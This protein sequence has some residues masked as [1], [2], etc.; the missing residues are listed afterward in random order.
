M[1]KL[2]KKVASYYELIKQ[3]RGEPM[4]SPKVF[5]SKKDKMKSSRD[6]R[7]STWRKEDREY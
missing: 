7:K 4:P 3:E 1:K 2:K 5:I 6:Y